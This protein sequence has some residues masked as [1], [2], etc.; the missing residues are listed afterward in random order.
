VDIFWLI[1]AGLIVVI[2]GTI[3]FVFLPWL[4]R[5]Q[6]KKTDNSV[7]AKSVLTGS[8]VPAIIASVAL[9]LFSASLYLAWNKSDTSTSSRSEKMQ[10]TTMA[11]E[12]VKA[13]NELAARLSRNP[14]DGKGWGMLARTYAITGRYNEAVDAYEKAAK[15]IKNDAVL[16][17]D[18][19]DVLAMVNGKNMKGKPLE[20]IRQ[21]L[22]LD[23][24]NVK[25]L[26]LIGTS[27][28]QAGD[29][30]QAEKHWSKLLP[31]LPP[32]S[33]LAKQ[34]NAGIADAQALAAGRQTP[35]KISGEKTQSGNG[36][37]QISG[38]V[39]LSPA[40]S[41]KVALSDTVFV[42]AKA[43]SGTPMPIAVI[44]AQVKDLPI[45]F[46]LDDS[47]AMMP[48]MKLSNHKNVTVSA[49]ISKSGNATP[50]SGDLKGEISSVK[51]G[52]DNIQIII[53]S[54]VP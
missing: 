6:S 17:V 50:Q 29:Y 40:L 11:P 8:R 9:F 49:K 34:I 41:D 47:M 27:A 32:D 25:G 19:A 1:V 18:Y 16:L 5:S 33:Q 23:P 14:E 42:F 35:P 10:G 30:K 2:A 12:H 52:A 3:L 28:F 48:T 53:D 20:L 36:G 31:M 15:L 37:A 38:V 39:K 21:A 24:N 13:I 4:R 26:A 43:I 22:E 7:E 44:R 51:V 46:V 54:V 45:K